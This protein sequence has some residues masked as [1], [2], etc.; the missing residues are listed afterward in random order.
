MSEQCR[1]QALEDKKLLRRWNRERRGIVL[2]EAHARVHT[3]AVS[4][5]REWT[6]GRRPI[7]QDAVSVLPRTASRQE[8]C[9][10]ARRYIGLGRCC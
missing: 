10:L 4:C 3:R 1:K 6:I 5:E 9:S 8:T 2:L 7:G